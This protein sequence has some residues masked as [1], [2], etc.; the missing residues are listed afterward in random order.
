MDYLKTFS[1]LRKLSLM[2]ASVLDD[3]NPS[4]SSRPVHCQHSRASMQ[5]V[6]YLVSNRANRS[7]SDAE[8][9]DKVE[10]STKMP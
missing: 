1:W 5:M 3:K 6:E 4:Q 10:T 2:S 7:I 9:V 8:L